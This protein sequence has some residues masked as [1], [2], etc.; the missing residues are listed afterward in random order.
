MKSMVRERYSLEGA[1]L[2]IGWLLVLLTMSMQYWSEEFTGD[3]DWDDG[4][5]KG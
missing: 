4:S 3:A 1:L 2:P 5:S